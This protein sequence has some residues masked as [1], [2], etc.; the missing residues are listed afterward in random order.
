MCGAIS[1]S[2]P[3]VFNNIT[4]IRLYA[5]GGIAFG[6]Q[7]T[8]MSKFNTLR[9][10]A[11]GCAVLAGALSAQANQKVCV[12]DIVGTNGDV[13]NLAKDYAIAMQK[14][15]A[16]IE[17]KGYVDERVATEDFRTGQC[18]AVIATG[19][20]TRQFNQVAGSLDSLGST[21]IVREGKIDIPATYEAVRKVIQ[22]FSSAAAAKDMVSGNYEVAGIIPGG[23]AYPIINDRKIDT[24]EELAGKKIA[25]F[26]YDKAQA[27]MIQKIGAQPVSADITNF[28]TKFNNGSV[29]M[30]GAPA[31]AY[32]PL[33][34]YKGIGTKGAVSRFPL[35]VLTFQVIVNKS[36]FPDGFGQKSR[37]YW[38]SQYDRALDLIKKAEASIPADKWMDLAPENSVKYTLMLRESRIDIANQGLYSKRGLK[39]IKKVRCSINPSDSECATQAELDWN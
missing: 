33:E 31:L 15:G 27:V 39:I 36:K 24:V 12:Y 9:R 37:E 11:I 6:T 18:D 14:A 8:L 30:I 28:A 21:T 25:A 4:A 7:E 23:A 22:V 34:L 13:F 35:L 38:V 1:G 17:L 10:V 32:K 5:V 2:M 16:S 3:P 19:F 26:D 20:R 29:D